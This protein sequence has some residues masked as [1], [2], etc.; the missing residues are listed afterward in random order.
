MDNQ[1]SRISEQKDQWLKSLQ[2]GEEIRK[3]STPSGID[4][5]AIYTPEEWDSTNYPEDLGYPGSFPF[6]RGVYPS[7][8]R[9]KLWT[10]R[11]YAGL[12][13]AEETNQRF[14]F[15]LDHGQTGLS[16]ALDLPTQMGYDSDHPLAEEEV[17]MVGVAIDTVDDMEIV[18]DQIPLDQIS[19]NFTI[20]APASVILAMYLVA[21]ERRGIPFKAL[22]GT[23]QNDI[24]KEYIAR[25]AYIFPPKP[26][27]RLIGDTIEYCSQYVPKFDPISITGYHA[28]EAG[29]NA[30]QEVAYTLLAGMT[31]V[32]MMLA[33]GMGVDS[34]AS[35][36]S[37]HF[38]SQ[39]N[40]FEEI[41]KIRAARRLWA[42]IVKERYGSNN[43]K[44]QMMRYFNGGSGASLSHEEP[45]NNIIRGTLQCLA[46][47][48]AG[49]QAC[50]VPSYDEA[51][52]IPTEES[53]LLSLRVQQI[54]AHESGAADVIDPLGGSY[55]I[56]SLTDK[57]ED[58]VNKL[59]E[60]IES[61]GGY[62][63]AIES[64]EIRQSIIDSAYAIQL[65]V[66]DGAKI[67]VGENAFKIERTTRQVVEGTQKDNT[68]ILQRQI[69]RL[70]R[71]KVSRDNQAVTSHS[72]N[73]RSVLPA[74]KI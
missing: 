40:I 45:L 1:N 17:G 44:S 27:L 59:L 67:I 43:P 58:E 25:N 34:F 21:A 48:L 49:A 15:L 50:H 12:G 56:E 66:E 19:V 22:S 20:N 26:S 51:Y 71:I 42:K 62:V 7:M 60:K 53:A 37:F 10:I 6:T 63:A 47:V 68:E 9:G 46:G 54:I 32:D 33:R 5:A 4:L 69:A 14:R 24:L 41:C 23:L 61:R 39:R 2:K 38:T 35:R 72:K 29:A 64:G 52:T 73:C 57:I 16:V 11:Q 31:Y 36:L 30:V 13:T 28:R 18:F 3:V 70:E 55:F 65:Q 74:L 8:Y